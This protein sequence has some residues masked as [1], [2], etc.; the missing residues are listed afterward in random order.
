MNLYDLES[1][2]TT[3]K[4]TF[5]LQF[6]FIKAEGPFKSL[7]NIENVFIKKFY[8]LIYNFLNTDN[9]ISPEKAK[10]IDLEKLCNYKDSF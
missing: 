3:K 2:A 9:V 5:N 1:G 4:K 7:S 6:I 8:I 10:R